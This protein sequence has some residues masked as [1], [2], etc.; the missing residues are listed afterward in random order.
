MKL[1]SIILLTAIFGFISLANASDIKYKIA[2]IPKELLKNAKVVI[3]TDEETFEIKS[4]SK[5][6]LK[7]KIAITILSE[8]EINKSVKFLGYD[9][10][11]RIGSFNATIYNEQGK[12]VKSLSR[13]DF[14]DVSAIQGFS[15]Y[16][17]SRVKFCDPKY[18]AVP[19][20]IEYTYDI[21]YSGLSYPDVR[22]IPSYYE[23]VEN[24]KFDVIANPN[25]IFR[26]TQNLISE[27][28]V[29]DL[30]REKHYSWQAKNLNAILKEDYSVPE[31]EIFPYLAIA[32]TNFEMDNY[33]GNCNTW[34]N[35][36]QFISQ[37][38]NNKNNLSK[39]TV[40][41][42][43]DYVKDA[44]T[45]FQ[46]IDMLYKYM[47]DKTRYVNISIGIGGF[48]PFDASVVDRLSY[49]DCKAL[50]NYM[51][52]L[53][54]VVGIDAKPLI[55][56]A[57][58]NAD[59]IINSFPCSQ[60][61]HEFLCVPMP[62]DTIWLECTASHGPVGFFGT[63][64]DDRDVLLIDGDK[65]KLIHTPSYSA[66]DNI[67]SNNVVV[68]ID[69]E[70]NGVA[71]SLA[72]YKG[73]NYEKIL[74]LA[75]I[76][77]K[78]KKKYLYQLIKIPN[79][80]IVDSKFTETQ[81]RI[82]YFDLSLD[83]KIRNYATIISDKILFSPNLMNKLTIVPSQINVR[84]SDIFVRRPLTEIDTVKYIIPDGFISTATS[85]TKELN[86][87]FGSYKYQISSTD[88]EIVYIRYFKL[89]KGRYPA[90]K[91]NDFVNFFENINTF[92]EIKT[93]FKK[94]S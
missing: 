31:I 87:M 92:D 59:P 17:D 2:D 85:Q 3:R 22:I 48:Q 53:L 61:N 47:Q 25:T 26:Y 20:T 76:D 10:F 65:S 51:K 58:K 24:F 86:T 15:L 64:T 77:N 49:G 63:F 40:A 81:N 52:T 94:K 54:E 93:A 14:Y 28:V 38:N 70:G 88:K 91:Y 68:K 13:D 7:V 84:K 6:T 16:E 75:M 69:N 80:E 78:D 41:K 50:T 35:F 39:E 29:S 57:D 12:K 60:F 1:K 79:F 89:N 33:K 90:D 62:N 34:N 11:V 66:D 45:D 46:K 18:H 44:K 9:K 8:T 30:K 67:T 23:S 43:K 73:I 36:G 19:F 5:S 27:P 37:L 21:D 32:P 56:R 72:R 82:P 42:I 71:Q 55:V 83:M 4:V 74:P